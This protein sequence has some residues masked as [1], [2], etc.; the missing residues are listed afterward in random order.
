MQSSK[1]LSR[2]HTCAFSARNPV[3]AAS[4]ETV[5]GDTSVKAVVQILLL[6]GGYL[7]LASQTAK[8]FLG[9]SLGRGPAS[10]ILRDGTQRPQCKHSPQ[11][12]MFIGPAL[13]KIKKNVCTMLHSIM[14][15]ENQPHQRLLLIYNK[16]L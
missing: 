5:Q 15:F 4:R 3:S 6:W 13:L 16:K 14:G 1:N 8:R 10:T 9:V 7:V 11:R 2:Y 12:L